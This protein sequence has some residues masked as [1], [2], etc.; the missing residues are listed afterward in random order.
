VIVI[1]VLNEQKIMSDSSVSE[2]GSES[3]R[4][5]KRHRNWGSSHSDYCESDDEDFGEK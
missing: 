4:D 5:Y 2:D 3:D 1:L